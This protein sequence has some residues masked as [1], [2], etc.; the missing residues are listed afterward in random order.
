M[1]KIKNISI[2][3]D[4]L[5]ITDKKN[6]KYTVTI[7]N[8][9]VAKLVPLA[10]DRSREIKKNIRY[11][12]K[13]R[14]ISFLLAVLCSLGTIVPVLMHKFY[15]EVFIVIFGSLG[16]VST[17]LVVANS[18]FINWLQKYCISN[19]Y[20]EE[21]YSK[22]LER[23]NN[24]EYKT[25]GNNINTQT[26]NKV[27]INKP[28]INHN[29]SPVNIQNISQNNSQEKNIYSCMIDNLNKDDNQ[30]VKTYKKV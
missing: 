1:F 30:K 20:W 29:P 9:A 4:F 15:A 28:N 12:K 14:M 2:N 21:V 25:Q 6:N 8:S 19:E 16:L 23:S 22:I 11:I 7:D 27:V 17:S 13:C 18:L 5:T 24:K 10:S 3:G 26:Y